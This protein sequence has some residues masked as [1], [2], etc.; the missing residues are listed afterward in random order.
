MNSCE[1]DGIKVQCDRDL[2]VKNIAASTVT[3]TV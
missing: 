2:L 3:G 1:G